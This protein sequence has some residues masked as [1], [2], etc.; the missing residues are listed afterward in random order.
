MED[1]QKFGVG[2]IALLV[3]SNN[4]WRV[5]IILPI[6]D[7]DGTWWYEVECVEHNVSE[8]IRKNFHREV[9]GNSLKVI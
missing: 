7:E 3:S 1:V 2:D 4:E 5:K 9:P 6:Q 8:N